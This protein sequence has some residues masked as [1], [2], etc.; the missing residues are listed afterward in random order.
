MRSSDAG[1]RTFLRSAGAIPL[2]AA[3]PL[4][5]Q[6]PIAS[7]A[8]VRGT[9][10]TTTANADIA[11]PEATARTMQRLRAIG[12][13]TVYVEA[14]KNGY[15]QWPSKVLERTL[16][17]AQRPASARQDPSDSAAPRPAR[18]LLQETLIE[19]HRQGLL[20]VAWFEYGFMAAHA[21]T[22]N[23]LRRLKPD[24]LSRDIRGNEVAPNGFVWMNPLH[25]EARRFLIELVREAV[26]TYDLD[27]IQFDDRIVWPGLTM[28]YDAFT[29]E[30]YAADHN[31]RAPPDNHLDADWKLWRARKLDEVARTFVAELRALRPGL[32]VSFSPA[33]FPW[34]YENYLLDWPSW[35]RWPERER[36]VEVVPQAY[37]L[38]YA[39][40]EATWREQV[41]AL[42]AAGV[43]RPAELVAGIRLVGDGRDSS[44]EQLRSSIN[45]VRGFAN[46]GHVLWFSRGVLGL[47]ERELTAF[48]GGAVPSPRFAP[49]WRQ[50]SVRGSEMLART[51]ATQRLWSFAGVAPGAWR[52]V[53]RSRKAGPGAPWRYLQDV[54]VREPGKAP[55]LPLPL[56]FD[57][58]ELL[59]DRRNG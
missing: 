45:L 18:D 57:E 24:W 21:S 27:G 43:Y 48:Y 40:F 25:P 17:V 46:G 16:G 15:T 26:Q 20:H 38:S 51:A 13:N 8:E 39:S 59:I 7:S 37:R 36:F 1:R 19:A 23:H 29:R 42:Q 22:Q 34:S 33:V 12:L 54:V 14:W 47:F 5:A 50:P 41:H 9:W 55:L 3:A 58:V 30:L 31:G 53:G 4:R 56:E 11:T 49:G 10:L 35:Q 32:M 52:A 44:W 6:A 2:A 28:G